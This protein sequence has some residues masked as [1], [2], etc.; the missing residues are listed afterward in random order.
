MSASAFC[1]SFKDL[2]AGGF[3][4]SRKLPICSSSF[5]Q[6]PIKTVRCSTH[7]YASSAVG[8]YGE[9]TVKCI[10]FCWT[11]MNP[12]QRKHWK[13]RRSE[14][15]WARGNFIDVLIRDQT[16]SWQKRSSYF[17]LKAALQ[18]SDVIF[19]TYQT[20]LAVILCSKC[21]VNQRKSWNSILASTNWLT[22]KAKHCT[23]LST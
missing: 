12:T 17:V 16:P 14:Q 10:R 1:N 7:S 6:V 3:F 22:D 23:S 13:R 9:I 15:G 11:E 18:W 19:W 2:M 5:P 4:C 20:V 8:G 21:H